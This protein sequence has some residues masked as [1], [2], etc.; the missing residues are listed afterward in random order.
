MDLYNETLQREAESAYKKFIKTSK[1]LFGI[2]KQRS[3]LESFKNIQKQE[4]AYNSSVLGIRDVKVD[5]IAGSV[6]K[7]KDFDKNFVPKNEVI[8]E[9]WKKIYVASMKG[10][11]LPPV[12]LYKIKD[13]YYVYDGNHR[14]SVAKFLNYPT[15]EAEVTEF[16][17]S[18]E[19]T[20]DTVYREKFIF[21]KETD[22]EDIFFTELGRYERLD[23]E[24]KLYKNF[25][26]EKKSLDCTYKE[27]AK[28]WHKD[29]F[30]SITGI[31][32][33]NSMT[34]YYSGFN[35]ND[36]FIFVLDHKYFINR[37][38]QGEQGYLY[39]VID[40]INMVKTN[41][42]ISLGN[43]CTVSEEKRN[44]FLK[45]RKID[46]EMKISSE[47]IKVNELLL[48]I[49]GIDFKYSDFT[50]E[51]IKDFQKI[52]KIDDITEAVKKWFNL[53]YAHTLK[54]F[55]IK[56][57]KLPEKYSRYL[58]FFTGNEKKIFE[59][60]HN[61][62][63]LHYYYGDTGEEGLIDWKNAILN[64]IV[65]IYIN[66]ID[67]IIESG[68]SQSKA[69]E[70]YYTVEKEYF[71]L[72]RNE[73]IL[74]SEKKNLNYSKIKEVESIFS[75]NWFGKKFRTDNISDI[76]TDERYEEFLK[77][78]TSKKNMQKFEK[79]YYKYNGI[80]IYSTFI[81]LEKAMKLTG[82]K[83]FIFDLE[84]NMKTLGNTGYIVKNYKTLEI[85]RSF[86]KEKENMSFLDFYA[87][88]LNHGVS[89]SPDFLFLNILDIALDY[90]N[91][92]KNIESCI[93]D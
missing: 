69:V 90:L 79:I 62:R 11:S 27:A 70:I 63:I 36:L 77:K 32:E 40:F 10:D 93:N 68:V 87:K 92:C 26:K 50:Y 72:L 91:N 39:A 14:V 64:Y 2:N 5:Q 52:H 31:L 61:F 42:D 13:I 80:N 16:L 8:K 20:E 57:K 3:G 41:E 37:E 46:K 6:E 44:S 4:Q 66:I 54:Y 24:I 83:E 58:K 25:L 53:V 15:I 89:A 38:K 59:S 12:I 21:E 74:E 7:Y 49:T 17:P 23:T 76:L 71:Y 18:G 43:K 88:I 67:G 73:K 48:K 28:Y 22:I 60:M 55:L 78:F 19:D 82:E 34:D 1:G 86:D 65:E 84:R 30:K 85:L 29:I 47:R 56:V 33:S 81:K 75:L 45:L 9:R 35:I 51:M